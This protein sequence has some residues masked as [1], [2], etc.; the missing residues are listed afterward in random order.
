MITYEFGIDDVAA[1]RFAVSPVHELVTSLVAL[2]DRD[3]AAVHRPWL[4]GL[5]GRVDGAALRPLVALVPTRGYTPDFLTPPPA[6]RGGEIGEELARIAATP[7]DQVVHDI[8]IAAEQ[9]G[10]DESLT[11]P[12]LRDPAAALARTVATMS[13]FWDVALAG[14]WGRIR[15]LLEGASPTGQPGWPPA[16]WRR[17]CATCTRRRTGA[18]T[19]WT[20]TPATTSSASWVAVAWC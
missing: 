5:S 7:L 6:G 18:G 15:A 20:S 10:H 13:D 8:S 2:R 16:G 12:W 1:M 17:P 14:P 11:G 19:A 3:T 4:Q 9:M